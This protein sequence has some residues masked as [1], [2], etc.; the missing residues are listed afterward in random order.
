MKTCSDRA[1]SLL[2]VVLLS[3]TAGANAGESSCPA[4]DLSGKWPTGRSR[5]ESSGHNGPLQ[6]SFCKIDETHYRVQFRG[7]FARIVPFRYTVT[8]EV[9]GNQGDKVLLSGSARLPLFGMFSYS[10]EATAHEF[11][12]TYSSCDD[13]GVFELKRC[14]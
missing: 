4:P 6:A 14:D 12:S 1:L 10:A 5:S 11:I 13:Q 8:L 2:F 9:I 3:C 7:R